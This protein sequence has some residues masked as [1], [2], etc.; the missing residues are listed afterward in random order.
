MNDGEVSWPKSTAR[1]KSETSI[2][3]EKFTTGEVKGGDENQ[4][5]SLKGVVRHIGKLAMSGHYTADANRNT[6]SEQKQQWVN[7]DDGISSLTSIDKIVVDESSQ[8][9][10]YMMI[11]ERE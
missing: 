7:F 4:E 6:L 11:Y 5:Y 3:L 2:S 1:V 8:M 9:N 10:N